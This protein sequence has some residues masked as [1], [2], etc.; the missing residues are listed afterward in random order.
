MGI[1]NCTMSSTLARFLSLPIFQVPLALL[2]VCMVGALWMAPSFEAAAYSVFA[3]FVWIAVGGL[4]P[5][6][7]IVASLVSGRG[8][9]RQQAMG[10]VFPYLLAF[11][12]PMCGIISGIS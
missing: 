2:G 3:E 11:A 6:L 5:V 1:H 9:G 8:G 12:C 10:A 7:A 4:M